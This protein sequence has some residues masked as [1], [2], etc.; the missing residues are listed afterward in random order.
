MEKRI[1]VTR[2]SMP[3]WEEYAEKIKVLWD[4]R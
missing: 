4:N 1:N 3:S 2:S